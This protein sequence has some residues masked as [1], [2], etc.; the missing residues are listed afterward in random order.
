MRILKLYSLSKFQL[1]NTV[2]SVIIVMLCISFSDVIHVI[3]ENFYPFTRLF[4]FPTISFSLEPQLSD[5][6]NKN[7]QFA[8]CQVIFDSKRGMFSPTFCFFSSVN[9]LYLDSI[10]P[11][12]C[13]LQ[14]YLLFY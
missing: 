7:S 4:L 3:T 1:H 10:V 6:L 5:R 9:C 8:D 13:F 12:S 2:L 11:W 14:I